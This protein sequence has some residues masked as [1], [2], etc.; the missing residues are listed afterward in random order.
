M[1]KKVIATSVANKDELI[2]RIKTF[3][4]SLFWVA[5]A[6]VADHSLANL[7]MLSLPSIDVLGTPVDT[8][9]IAGLVLNQISKF[10]FNMRNKNQ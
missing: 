6:A 4:W 1:T 2:K 7:G 10:A 5:I 9:I 8:A 3:A